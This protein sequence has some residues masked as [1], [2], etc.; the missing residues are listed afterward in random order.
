[1]L[2]LG[3]LAA[4]G[5]AHSADLGPSG[6]EVAHYAAH[7]EARVGVLYHDFM[8]KETGVDLNAE[9]LSAWL[10]VG[11]RIPG[12]DTLG[13]LRPH[14]GGNVNLNGDTSQIYAGY[15]L[16]LNL[17]ERVFIEGS[18]GGMAHNGKHLSATNNRLSLGCSVM[19]R[20]SASL[21]VRIYDNWSLVATV[22]HASNGGLCEPNNGLT[23]AGVRVGYSF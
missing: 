23:N 18:F 11:F 8:H 2:A 10:A 6:A 12:L 5:A 7:H 22:S 20:E 19:F 9:Y 17:T 4:P 21:G 16:T 15:S 3:V 1:M 13:Q 14:I